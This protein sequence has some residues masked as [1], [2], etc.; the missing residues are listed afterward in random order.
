MCYDKQ[1]SVTTE[2]PIAKTDPDFGDAIN[3]VRHPQEG[4]QSLPLRNTGEAKR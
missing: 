2:G 1:A 3:P 4:S